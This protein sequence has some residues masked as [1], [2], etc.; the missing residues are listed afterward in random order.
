MEGLNCAATVEV[1]YPAQA[2]CA[3]GPFYEKES[4][5]LLWV[6]ISKNSVNCYD[7]T[8]NQNKCVHADEFFKGGIVVQL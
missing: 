3:E 8:T 2:T 5:S 4:N 7:L 6:D 1:L